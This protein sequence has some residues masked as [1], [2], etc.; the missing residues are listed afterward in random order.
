MVDTY[1]IIVY[2]IITIKQ[3][4]YNIMKNKIFIAINAY[5][6]IK[7]FNT[8][9]QALDFGE[10]NA[11]F[12]YFSVDKGAFNSLLKTAKSAGIAN[13]LNFAFNRLHSERK[14]QAI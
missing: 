10:N 2:N 4:S 14:T 7:K 5:G 9:N 1:I 12:Q 11:G 3:G 13:A 8:Y 6:T